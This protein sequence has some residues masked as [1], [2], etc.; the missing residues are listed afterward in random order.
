MIKPVYNHFCFLPWVVLL[1]K[2]VSLTASG[3]WAAGGTPYP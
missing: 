1:L 2:T 3:F